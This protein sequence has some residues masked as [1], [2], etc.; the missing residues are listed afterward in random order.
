MNTFKTKLD[1]DKDN[2]VNRKI[3]QKKMSIKKKK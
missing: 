3:D 1:R 2:L